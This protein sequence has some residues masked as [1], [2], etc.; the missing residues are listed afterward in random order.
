MTDQVAI[1]LDGGFVKKRL[2][3]RLGHFPTTDDVVA[4]TQTVMG[5][6]RLKTS[7][8][9]RVFYYDAPPYEGTRGRSRRR[10]TWRTRAGS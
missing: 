4:L 8:L 2:S 5:H 6:D 7:R 10:W 9:F 1:L 3:D